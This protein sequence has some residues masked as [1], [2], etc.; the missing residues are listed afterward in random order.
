MKK[1]ICSLLCSGLMFLFLLHTLSSA[2]NSQ[3][4]ENDTETPIPASIIKDAAYYTEEGKPLN[5]Y[6]IVTSVTEDGVQVYG[7]FA[8]DGNIIASM[9]ENEDCIVIAYTDGR[10]YTF[11][12]NENGYID[13][14]N[15]KKTITHIDYSITQDDHAKT[16]IPYAVQ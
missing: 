3:T 2:L 13:F 16:S 10:M 9:L 12:K 1:M 14:S 5:Q 15:V 7:F 4:N 8:K 11:E 6:D